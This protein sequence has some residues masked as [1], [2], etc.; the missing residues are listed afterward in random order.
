MC[1]SDLED[2]AELVQAY[3]A[4]RRLK[5]NEVQKGLGVGNAVKYAA[6]TGTVLIRWDGARAPEIWT[7]PRPEIEPQAARSELA[8]RYL[9]VF[10]PATPASL[11]AWAGIGDP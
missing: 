1:S 6:P 2:M 5:D 11:A 7:A 4:G 3:L 10:G 9:H 8:R